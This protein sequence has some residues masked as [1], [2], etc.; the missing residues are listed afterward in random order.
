VS[1]L[2]NFFFMGPLRHLHQFIFILKARPNPF[3]NTNQL[4]PFMYHFEKKICYEIIYCNNI[5][6]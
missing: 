1:L 3:I 4:A 5:Y 6:V 2:V